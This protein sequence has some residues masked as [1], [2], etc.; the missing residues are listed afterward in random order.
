MVVHNQIIARM[1]SRGA[2]ATPFRGVDTVVRGDLAD[3]IGGTKTRTVELRRKSV[4]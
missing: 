2:A 4:R 1:E 3:E